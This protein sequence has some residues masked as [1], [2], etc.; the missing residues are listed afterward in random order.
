MTSEEVSLRVEAQAGTV[1]HSFKL[2][3]MESLGIIRVALLGILLAVLSIGAYIDLKKY[4]D[5]PIARKEA[6]EYEQI[7][8]FPAVTVCPFADS[9]IEDAMA[10]DTNATFNQAI[11]MAISPVI[12]EKYYT[13]FK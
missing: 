12:Y 3:N 2:Q 6:L 11:D 13:I 10:L 5:S 7:E 9:E 1:S 4:V 8:F